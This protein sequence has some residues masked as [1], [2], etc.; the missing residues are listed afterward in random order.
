MSN[1]NLNKISEISEKIIRMEEL[2]LNTSALQEMLKRAMQEP[3]EPE[4]GQ[5]EIPEKKPG[6]DYCCSFK[7]GRI[8]CVTGR[9]N[10]YDEAMYTALY[11]AI[12]SEVLQNQIRY[13]LEQKAKEFGGTALAKMFNQTCN[14]KKREIRKQREEEKRAIERKAAEGREEEK[15]RAHMT[16]FSDIPE[17]CKNLYIGSGWIADDNGIYMLEEHGKTIRKI[18][19]MRF[20]FLIECLYEPYD[21]GVTSAEKCGV[22]FKSVHGDWRKKIVE[23]STLM[24]AQ[25]ALSLAESGVVINSRRALPFTDFVTSM[26]EEST[27]RKAIPVHKMAST[28]G[29]TS[30]GKEF[31]PYTS[32]ECVFEKE[33]QY[34]ELLHNLTTEA[35]KYEDW[36]TIYKE[37]RA[38]RV[39][40][41]NF[42]TIALLAS[43]IVGMLPDVGN[44][45]ICNIY[46]NTHTGKTICTQMAGTIWGRT[47]KDGYAVTMNGTYAGME[48]R[49]NAMKNIPL[50]IEDANNTKNPE[51]IPR[52]IMMASNGMGAL[53][54]TKNMGNRTLY[55]WNM[56]VLTNSEATLT[57]Y[58]H[59]GGKAGNGGIYTRT[60]ETKSE[61]TFPKAWEANADKWKQ[62]FAVNYGHAGRRFVEILKKVGVANIQKLK[63]D[64]MKEIRKKAEKAG[65]SAEQAEG[66]AILMVADYLSEQ[67][68]FQDGVTFTV[69]EMLEFTAEKDTVRPAVRFYGKLEDIMIGNPDRF[70]GLDEEKME[71]I[72]DPNNP[73]TWQGEFWGIYMKQDG[74]R[75][76]CIRGDIL[77]K[78][79]AEYGVD[80][81][82]FLE[83]LR[84]NDLID[85]DAN[86]TSRKIWSSVKKDRVRLIKIKLDKSLYDGE[87]VGE[88]K[89]KPKK[90]P[91]PKEEP[92]AV[93]GYKEAEQIPFEW[94]A[95][96]INNRKKTA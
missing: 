4:G 45:F 69:E 88:E 92:K 9:D 54:A 77:D 32:K 7:S 57:S 33:D 44:G 89:P 82:L 49:M 34:P 94:A 35:G 20:P 74:D 96:D 72:E 56:T 2:G 6:V 93:A 40:M 36:L 61:K 39:K 78:W 41:F 90:E 60:Y 81:G 30:D 53:R 12:P 38:T 83:Y 79:L 27:L 43:P 65:R 16:S 29:W 11:G 70:E 18:E 21:A 24:N 51:D 47:G 59:N 23:Q 28:L 86:C 73:R 13:K 80:R 25:K 64:F 50:I 22:R 68:L 1:T 8:D 76:L 91:K 58:G 52:F 3:A 71:Q 15:N 5:E 85:S 14:A 87:C 37:V 46:G 19:A 84:E 75:W 95:K 17:G 10:F 63:S 48:T 26:L 55:K 42:A 66:L 62:F 31:L 67:Y